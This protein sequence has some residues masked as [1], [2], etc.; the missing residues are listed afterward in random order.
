MKKLLLAS[1]LVT[2]AVANA[3]SG[4]ILSEKIKPKFYKTLERDLDVLDGL[5]FKAA[6][7]ETLELMGVSTL[8]ARTASE[9]LGTRVNYVIEENALSVFKLLIKRVIFEERAHATFPN[10]DILPYSID[11]ANAKPAVDE[12]EGVTVMSNIGAALY[13]GGKQESKVYGM[14]ISRGLL[15]K[16]IKV[17]VESP[18]AGIIQVGEGLF[19][20]RLTINPEKPNSIANSINRLA[21]FFHEARHSDGN[22]SSVGFLHSPCPVGHDYAGLPACDE[23]LNGPYTV[24]AVMMAEMLKACE[25]TCSIREKEIL[26]LQVLDSKN[27]IMHTTRKGVAATV[28]DA[29]P[30]SL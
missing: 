30:E 9:W 2:S 7:A 19:M 16:S 22:G 3:G 24:G 28:W 25:D 23:N 21:T 10:K 20:D 4:I 15:K 1:L 13:Y 27:R 29:R 17:A 14:K 8:N 18:R 26:K 11:P 6:D 12:E 5:K